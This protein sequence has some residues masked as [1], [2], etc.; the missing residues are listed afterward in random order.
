MEIYE[1]TRQ[2]KVL[3]LF[4]Q[5]EDRLPRTP[6]PFI[7]ED[8]VVSTNGWAVCAV[9]PG[10]CNGAYTELETI[11]NDFLSV[12]KFQIPDTEPQTITFDQI[13]A[14]ISDDIKAFR[15]SREGCETCGDSGSCEECECGSAHACG[16]CDG[17]GSIEVPPKK[18]IA[19]SSC[20]FTFF[21]F[22]YLVR[23]AS[24][25]D[26]TEFE[27]F[28]SNQSGFLNYFRVG[29]FDILLS[30]THVSEGQEPVDILPF[31]VSK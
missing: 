1:M 21:R 30:S 29:E 17:V 12:L 18:L 5:S 26:L 7:V 9:D 6:I 27:Y 15:P 31:G 23:A 24:I 2:E 3:Q 8:R 14:A 13:K 28:G 22:E 20:A 10:L 25:L 11:S 4:V 16:K 19:L